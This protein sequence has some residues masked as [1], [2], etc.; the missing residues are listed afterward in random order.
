MISREPTQLM[1]G[2]ATWVGQFDHVMAVHVF[3]LYPFQALVFLAALVAYYRVPRVGFQNAILL[4]LAADVTWYI[5]PM[6]FLLSFAGGALEWSIAVRIHRSRE[7]RVRWALLATSIATNL[8]ILGIM[9]SGFLQD[10][11]LAGIRLLGAPQFADRQVVNFFAVGFNVFVL[12]SKISLT[13]DVFQEQVGKEPGFW[14][15]MVFLTLF[16]RS[17]GFPIDRAKDTLPQFDTR[18]E[19]S[20]RRAGESFWLLFRGL[21]QLALY[22]EISQPAHNLLGENSSGL[23]VVAGAWVFMIGAWLLFSGVVDAARA[24]AWMFGIWVPPNFDAPYLSVNIGE[25]WRRWNMTVST[26][27][28]EYAFGKI[29]F[30]LRNWGYWSISI[31]CAVTFIGC[32]LAH[33]LTWGNVAWGTLQGGSMFLYVVSRKRV[34]KWAKAMGNPR[35]IAVGAW[36]LTINIVVVSFMIDSDDCH[37][38]TT[39]MLK[40][41][42]LGPIWPAIAAG[43]DWTRILVTCALAMVLQAIPHFKGGDQWMSALRPRYRWAVGIV[44]M[45]IILLSNWSNPL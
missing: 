42:F 29:T 34:R 1:H 21:L 7:R 32:G 16:S 12:F 30:A 33:G 20:W 5:S 37:C 24:S 25:F 19:W 43:V 44:W 23:G 10:G 8:V 14:R 41:I 9:L 26:W 22:H 2:I 35:W 27:F 28:N 40:S 18:R 4:I 11:F 36:F 6:F 31:A 45:T 15:S 38:A 13:L 17:G 39:G 3:W